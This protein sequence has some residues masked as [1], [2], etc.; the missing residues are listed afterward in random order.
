M[1]IHV[2]ILMNVQFQM[3]VARIDVLILREDLDVIAR[4]ICICMLMEELVEK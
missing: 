1:E 4:R 2:V 3:E